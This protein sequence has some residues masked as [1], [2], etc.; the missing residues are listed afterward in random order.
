MSQE[1]WSMVGQS[2][3]EAGMFCLLLCLWCCSSGVSQLKTWALWCSLHCVCSCRV[4]WTVSFPAAGIS[5]EEW[6]QNQQ[7]DR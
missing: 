2:G 5:H 3:Y 4:K 6:E 7:S 1:Q